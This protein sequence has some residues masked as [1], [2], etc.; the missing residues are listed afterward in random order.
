MLLSWSF[1]PSKEGFKVPS[2]ALQCVFG[3]VSIPLR[4]VS[5]DKISQEFCDL[6]EVSIP[7]RKVSRHATRRGELPNLLVSIPL[8][9]VSRGCIPGLLGSG[10]NS[11]HPSKEGF[12]VANSHYPL[13]NVETVS[14]PLRKVSR[15]RGICYGVLEL[16]KFPSL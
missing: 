4:K 7:L 14:I 12:K 1:H 8:R 13:V 6:G 5:R 2:G 16:W 3:L 10:W 11:F 15:A 9:K